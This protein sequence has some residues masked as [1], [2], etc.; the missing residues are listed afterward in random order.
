MND[1]TSEFV[2]SVFDAVATRLQRAGYDLR[3]PGIFTRPLENQSD[4]HGW[5]GLN[6]A[7]RG[8]AGG[9]DINPVVGVSHAGV[10]SALVELRG[11]RPD[12][13]IAPAPSVALPV[14]YLMPD[15]SF[16]AC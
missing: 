7:E 12:P 14:G 2:N 15:P 10:E 9:V 11:V 1:A 16:R 8:R 3:D 6:T 5:V 4:V 13:D